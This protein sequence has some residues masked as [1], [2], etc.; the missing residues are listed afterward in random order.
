MGLAGNLVGAAR[1]EFEVECCVVHSCRDRFV[2]L[3]NTSAT[4][5]NYLCICLGRHGLGRVLGVLVCANVHP[6][7]NINA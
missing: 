1:S 5:Y 2:G 6:N 4:D 3:L 7:R